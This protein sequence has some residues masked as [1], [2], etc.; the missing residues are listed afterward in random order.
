MVHITSNSNISQNRYSKMKFI[1]C[2]VVSDGQTYFSV[3]STHGIKEVKYL[4]V[5]VN[6]NSTGYT[7]LESI[8]T[9]I[10]VAGLKVFPD[11]FP[12][13]NWLDEHSKVIMEFTISNFDEQSHHI[14]TKH[15]L[16]I[17]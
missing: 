17:L 11:N 12:S 15:K 3:L 2:S 10:R 9:D 7:D 5:R 16:G 4:P 6:T 8:I 13:K 14:L 1:L